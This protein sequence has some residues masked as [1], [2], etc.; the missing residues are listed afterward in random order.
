MKANQR[1][2]LQGRTF[3]QVR[4]RDRENLSVRTTGL[5]L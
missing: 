3:L 5:Q 1:G 2:V 4:N